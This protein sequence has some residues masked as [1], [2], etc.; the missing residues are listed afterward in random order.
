MREGASAHESEERSHSN[1][2][3]CQCGQLPVGEESKDQGQDPLG[4][5]RAE[6][7]GQEEGCDEN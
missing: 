7:H 5:C 3:R 4:Q 2:E 6:R 1:P